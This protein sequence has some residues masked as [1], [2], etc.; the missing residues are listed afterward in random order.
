MQTKNKTKRSAHV[1]M[2]LPT[3]WDT[4]YAKYLPQGE[5]RQTPR[6]EVPLGESAF[7]F[8]EWVGEIK[9]HIKRRETLTSK[10]TSPTSSSPFEKS[11][12]AGSLER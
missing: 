3:K 6:I 9:K 10:N 1:G 2:W 12:S 11:G 7:G 8:Q 4:A 5:N